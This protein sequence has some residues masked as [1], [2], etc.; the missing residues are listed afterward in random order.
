MKRDSRAPFWAMLEWDI[1]RRAHAKDNR[2]RLSGP[3]KRFVRKEGLFKL[4]AVDGRW[5][6]NNLCAYFGH[7]GHGYVHE[8]IPHSEIWVST[9]HYHESAWE[10]GHCGCRV[11]SKGQRVSRNYFQSTVIHEITEYQQMRMGVPYW[12]AHQIALQNERAAGLLPDPFDD[13][14]RKRGGKKKK[15]RTRR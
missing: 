11:R 6:R 1:Q 5:I 4:Y 14:G 12:Q 7:G 13:T 9:H 3:W 10:G 2:V 15:K 8:F